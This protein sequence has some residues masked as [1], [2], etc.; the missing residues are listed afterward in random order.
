MGGGAAQGRVAAEDVPKL[1]AVAVSAGNA[2][3]CLQQVR[4]LGNRISTKPANAGF[5]ID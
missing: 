5:F 1:L 4:S 2:P 3:W